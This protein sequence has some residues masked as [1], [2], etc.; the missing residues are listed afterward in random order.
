MVDILDTTQKKRLVEVLQLHKRTVLY[1]A[2]WV[3]VQYLRDIVGEGRQISYFVDGDKNKQGTKLNGIMVKSPYDL[4]EEDKDNIAVILAMSS[5]EGAEAILQSFGWEEQKQYFKLYMHMGKQCDLYDPLLG[6]SRDDDIEGYKIIDHRDASGEGLRIV[7]L[8]GSTTDHSMSGLRSWPEMLGNMLIADSHKFI[9]Y[10][11]GITGYASAQ[12]TLKLMRD[13][14]VLRPDIVIQWSGFNDAAG[15]INSETHPYISCYLRNASYSLVRQ[16]F[17]SRHAEGQPPIKG[18]SKVGLGLENEVEIAEHW[19]KN[20]KIAE[21][22]CGIYQCS[23][24]GFLQPMLF[25][26][27]KDNVFCADEKEAV[28]IELDKMNGGDIQMRNRFY[29][30]AEECIKDEKRIYNMTKL[31]DDEV[32]VFYDI[33]HVNEHGNEIIAKAIYEKIKCIWEKG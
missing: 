27:R 8:G 28:S 23:Y 22:I 13:I 20:C 15:K 33:C 10:N 17:I 24:F 30:R 29:R 32:G 26:G 16:G 31:F 6:C 14:P 3:G 12:E 21:A 19:Y 11:G 2:G 4:L 9:L 18:V 25:E 7:A 1:G 5:P